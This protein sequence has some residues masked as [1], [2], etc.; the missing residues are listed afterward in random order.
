MRIFVNRSVGSILREETI[1]GRRHVVVPMV[2]LRVGV[3]QGVTADME[4][5]AATY[6]PETSLRA[7]TPRLEGIPVTVMHP[8]AEGQLVSAHSPQGQSFVVGWVTTP[9][10]V[11]GHPYAE[12]VIDYERL[13]SSSPQTLEM[14]QTGSP[15]DVSVGISGAQAQEAS[16]L[17]NGETYNEVLSDIEFDHVA[18]LP[19]RRGACSWADGCGVRVNVCGCTDQQET[20]EH[21]E[22]PTMNLKT[23][24]TTLL[25]RPSEPSAPT[26]PVNPL[27]AL[28]DRIIADMDNDF[29]ATDRD[30]LLGLSE[31]QLVW[32]ANEVS[33]SDIERQLSIF[34]NSLDTPQYI[35]YYRDA[36]P[37]A[38]YFI[39]ETQ[40]RNAMTGVTTARQLYKRTFE[41]AAETGKVTI[42]DDAQAVTEQRTY[43]PVA[44]STANTQPCQTNEG[45]GSMSKDQIIANLIACD[46]TP[47]SEANRPALSTLDESTLK[48]LHADNFKGKVEAPPAAPPVAPTVANAQP[49]APEAPKAKTVQEYLDAAPPE[50]RDVLGEAYADRE[51]SKANL[52]EQLVAN[53]APF[54]KEELQAKNLPELRKL[55]LMAKIDVA[56]DYSGNGG[57][58]TVDRANV[59]EFG[60]PDLPSPAP[61]EQPK[62]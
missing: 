26:A 61:A 10:F 60:V 49:P 22:E 20:S 5:G 25:R 23:I 44:P 41:V 36:Y 21:K 35:N 28:A 46:R 56:P 18:L 9:R 24:L 2:P 31:K 8:A 13:S 4:P 53:K 59:G 58:P 42:A 38:G 11:N 62:K 55:G 27:A 14:L 54:T 34:V 50:I 39:Y 16:G 1:N 45:N 33:L 7:S 43:V 12:A 32:L 48:L 57:T 47:F 6:Y 3:H 30:F 19:G 37:Q 17:W 15:M 51:A 40:V 52:I 29:A